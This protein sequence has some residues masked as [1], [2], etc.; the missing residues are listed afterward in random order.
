MVRKKKTKK[1]MFW[2]LMNRKNGASYTSYC[3]CAALIIHRLRY[4]KIFFSSRAYIVIGDRRK[5][6][7]RLKCVLSIFC[8]YLPVLCLT[9]QNFFRRD[10]VVVL[11]VISFFFA[12]QSALFRHDAVVEYNQRATVVA[13]CCRNL[14]A[15]E[16]KREN[17]ICTSTRRSR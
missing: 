8:C 10:L 16:T 1:T 11:P 4:I 7:R 17:T 3:V 15:K 13:V 9:P 6:R 5:F 2:I 14:R 12:S